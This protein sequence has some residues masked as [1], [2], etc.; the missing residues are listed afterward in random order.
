MT[1]IW[2]M[3]FRI[4]GAVVVILHG[5][6]GQRFPSHMEL[7]EVA[8]GRHRENPGRGEAFGL[9]GMLAFGRQAAHG[10]GS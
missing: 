9:I 5:D 8:G 10:G 2:K 4:S 3:R 6:L 1:S 7:V